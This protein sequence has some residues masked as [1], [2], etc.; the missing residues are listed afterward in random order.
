MALAGCPDSFLHH[1]YRI[2]SVDQTAHSRRDLVQPGFQEQSSRISLNHQDDD[3]DL[4]ALVNDMNSSFESLYSTYSMHSESKPL[5]QNGQLGRSQPQP[6]SGTNVLQQKV[7]RS[8]PVRITAVRRLQEEERQ[9]R[10]SSLP[11]IPN[12][13]PELCSPTSSPV[14]A[15]GSLPQSQPANKQSG[16]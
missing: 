14:L 3:V 10:T 16:A 6:A 9:F 5:L 13:F 12:P 4:E 1:P 11:A 8:Q 2:D 15:P 7:N